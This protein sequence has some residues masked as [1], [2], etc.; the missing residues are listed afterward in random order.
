VRRY[1]GDRE[2]R[3]KSFSISIN[4]MVVVNTEELSSEEQESKNVGDVPAAAPVAVGENNNNNSSSNNNK[5]AAAVVTNAAAAAA[6]MEV[7]S[8]TTIAHQEEEEEEAKQEEKGQEEESLFLR[9]SDS[10]TCT[11]DVVVAARE[12]GDMLTALLGRG[13]G[14]GGGGGGGQFDVELGTSSRADATS[15]LPLPNLNVVIMV[16]GTHGDVL[17]FCGLAKVLQK[18]GHRVRIASHEVHRNIIISNKIEFYPMA[19]DP[20]LLSQWMVQT[21]KFYFSFFVFFFSMFV[22]ELR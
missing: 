2:R 9:G 4:T 20:K 18:Q 5:G 8:T 7:D 10:T 19:G 11:D 14:G 21:G 1:C 6:V 17:P 15:R 22:K 12:K 16:V 3:E 13:G